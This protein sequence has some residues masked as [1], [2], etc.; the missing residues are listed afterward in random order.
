MIQRIHY[1]DRF[2]PFYETPMI[3]VLTGLRRSGKSTMLLLIQQDL[4]MR[5]ADSDLFF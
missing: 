2:R 4:R 1:L 5:G 3:K